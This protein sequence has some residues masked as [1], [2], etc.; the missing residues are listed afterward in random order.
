M[1][2][3]INPSS[4]CA[5]SVETEAALSRKLFG[6]ALPAADQ[7]EL[8]SHL[9]AC[10]HCRALLADLQQSH[11]ILE[12]ELFKARAP[13]TLLPRVLAKLPQSIPGQVSAPA[14]SGSLRVVA[15]SGKRSGSWW[16]PLAAAMVAAIAVVVGLSVFRK[17]DNAVTQV[18]R[19]SL[20]DSNGRLVKKI[21]A[22]ETYTAEAET[23]VPL[24]AD[25][26]IKFVEGA[27][28]AVQ[29]ASPGQQGSSP[30]L[31][32]QRGDLYAHGTGNSAEQATLVAC[33]AFEA[34]LQ[35]GDFFVSEDDAHDPRGVLIV[36]DGVA[37]VGPARDP[38]QVPS[39]HVFVSVKDANDPINELMTMADVFE[40][41]QQDISIQGVRST[42]MREEYARK[43]SG[44]DKELKE[45]ALAVANESDAVKRGELQER[46]S[47]VKEYR[48]QHQKRLKTMRSEFPTDQ[49]RRGLNRHVAPDRWM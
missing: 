22:G 31:L 15:V 13:R 23:I 5:R 17:D 33:D 28:F 37:T 10:A 21:L 43:V 32:L 9:A 30:G 47:R 12:A 2:E 18:E 27:Q 34:R 46:Q 26:R 3:A 36:F 41:M 49:I 20:R 7:A 16:I 8:D 39:G 42:S 38:L 11:Q 1:N 24:H 14:D 19:G 4:A 6:E 40:R 25:A 48:A 29:G 45:L 35:K 44:Y